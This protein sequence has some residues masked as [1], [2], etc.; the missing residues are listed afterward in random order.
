MATYDEQSL[1]Q[2]IGR[3]ELSLLTSTIYHTNLLNAVI[4]ATIALCTVAGFAIAQSP[5]GLISLFLALWIESPRESIDKRSALEQVGL[6]R[7]KG[8]ETRGNIRLS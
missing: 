4:L 2:D 7:R 6:V 8:Q 3:N 5:Y 1:W